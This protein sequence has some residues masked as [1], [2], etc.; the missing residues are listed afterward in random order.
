LESHYAP[1]RK[2]VLGDL[3]ELLLKFHNKEVGV[4][5]FQKRRTEIQLEKQKVL[6]TTGNLEEAARNLFAA[7][8][9]M[10]KLD[11][12][13]ILAEKAPNHGLGKAIND[14]LKRASAL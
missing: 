14:R 4:I 1:R 12:E 5:S 9:E 13:I 10:D 7:L 3:E 2:L 6:S 11:I 8:R